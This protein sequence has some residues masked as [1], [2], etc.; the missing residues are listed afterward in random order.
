[1]PNAG[2]PGGYSRTGQGDSP[3]ANATA[4][5]ADAN[6]EVAGRPGNSRS[7][8]SAAGGGASGSSGDGGGSDV[9][10]ASSAMGAPSITLPPAET[11]GLAKQRGKNWGLRY[12]EPSATPITRP[13]RILCDAR[14]MIILPDDRKR[15]PRPIAFTG[16]TQDSV[17]AM[18]TAVWDEIGRWGIAG[19]GMTWRPIL[20][21][22]VQ[23]GG[24]ARYQ[25]IDRMLKGSGLQV[26]RSASAEE[27]RAPSYGGRR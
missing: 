17:D 10:G 27:A 8:S 15:A 9:G 16:K 20:T 3:N 1:M 26:R 21:F 12:V 5:S 19:K 23:P 2:K 22:D 14:Q 6:S 24:E 13:V 18:V 7:N 11:D 4:N 25:E